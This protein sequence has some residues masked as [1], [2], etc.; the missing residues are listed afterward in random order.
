MLE[1]RLAAVMPDELS[2][3]DAL[4]LIYE[5]KGLLANRE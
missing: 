4:A 3:R 2:P 5:L 1:K